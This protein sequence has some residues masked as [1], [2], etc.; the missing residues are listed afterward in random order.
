[1]CVGGCHRIGIWRGRARH[2][3]TGLEMRLP[4]LA[5]FQENSVQSTREAY[6]RK[7]NCESN[8]EASVAMGT[9]L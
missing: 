7:Q 3:S 4:D 6:L 1:M 8:L 9:Y 5:G 2:R